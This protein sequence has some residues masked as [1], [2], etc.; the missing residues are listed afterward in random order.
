M[1]VAIIFIIYMGVHLCV[2]R[3]REED[4]KNKI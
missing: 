2:Y 3:G 1:A 4:L